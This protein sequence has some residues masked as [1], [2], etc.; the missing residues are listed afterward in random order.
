MNRVGNPVGRVHVVGATPVIAGVFTQVEKLFDV[1]VPGF[2]IGTDCPF[3]LAALIDRHG[4]VIHDFKERH[5]TLALA[6]SA[7]DIGAQGPT[8]VQSLPRPPANFDSMAL[9]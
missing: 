7:F 9:S 8:G 2:Q 5:D 6:V 4:G 3:T 1:H